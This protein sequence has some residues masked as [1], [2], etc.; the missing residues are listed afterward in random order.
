MIMIRISP[1]KRETKIQPSRDVKSHIKPP[2]LP[3]QVYPQPIIRL[4]PRPPD[5]LGSNPKV[6]AEIEINLD[7]EEIS[8]QSARHNNRNV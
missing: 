4:P 6:T 2:N 8:T 3:N 7:F 1:I 5:P